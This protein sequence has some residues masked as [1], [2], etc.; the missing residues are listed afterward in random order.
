LGNVNVNA[1]GSAFPAGCGGAG[2]AECKNLRDA[3]TRAR[4][5]AQRFLRDADQGFNAFKTIGITCA[6]EYAATDAAGAQ[7]IAKTMLTLPEQ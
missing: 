4:D 1:I 6:N 5:E 3:M 7:G 2:L